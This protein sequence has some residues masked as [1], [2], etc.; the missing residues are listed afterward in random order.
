MIEFNPVTED[1]PNYQ[2]DNMSS[3]RPIVFTSKNKKIIGTF[4]TAA[5]QGKKPTVVLLHGLPGNENNF[6]IAHAIKR[7]GFNVIVFHY[8]GSWGS[9]DTFSISKAI[10]DVENAIVYFSCDEVSEEFNIDSNNLILIGH[11]MGGFISLYVSKKFSQI[12]NIVSLA[13]F[14]FGYFS[15]FLLQNP[16]YIEQ[17]KEGLSQVAAL[18][19]GTN[20]ELLFNEMTK[21]TH[22]WNLLN[23]VSELKEKNILLIGSEYDFVAPLSI[24]HYPLVEGL[25]KVGAKVENYVYRS[26]HSFGSARIKLTTEIIN[27]MKTLKL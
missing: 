10:E 23:N 1:N 26:G 13:G 14:N 16:E 9:E 6:D 19:N 20:S 5:G 18:L 25:K 2:N 15:E 22:D 7:Y 24:H 27:W 11:S 21:H 12:K 4:F 3:M 17:T 8:R